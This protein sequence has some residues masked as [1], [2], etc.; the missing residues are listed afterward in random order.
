MMRPLMLT[1]CV[2]ACAC[3]RESSEDTSEP[4]TTAAP[5]QAAPPEPTAE[6][7]PVPA[8]FEADARTTITQ[9]S[10]KAEL[11]QLAQEIDADSK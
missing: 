8:D 11:A 5:E 1:L 6:Q 4:G 2:L 10:Y 3:T 7:V 9:A